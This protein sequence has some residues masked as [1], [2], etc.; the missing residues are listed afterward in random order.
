M[1]ATE[2]LHKL[3]QSPLWLDNITRD[4]LTTGNAGRR[5]INELS[6][7]GD[8]PSNPDN[9]R[10]RHQE[11]APPMTPRSARGSSKAKA[12][13]GTV[14][15][16][17][18]RRYHRGG[19]TVFDRSGRGPGG[20]DVGCHWKSPPPLGPR[21][22]EHARRGEGNCI[23]AP[24]LHNLFIKIPGHEGEGLPAIEEAIFCWHSSQRDSPVLSGALRSRRAEAI[25]A[26]GIERRRI[27]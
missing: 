17:G 1:N 16:A 24:R 12:G 15:R 13:E 5:Y 25:S 11:Q 3:G 21:H 18:A 8:S 14:L 26:R 19:R 23:A 10:Q 7:N 9:L 2:A 4:L 22:S 20:V 6:V 27:E